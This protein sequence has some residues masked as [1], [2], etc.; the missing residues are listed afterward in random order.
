MKIGRSGTSLC[1]KVHN[2]G[3][4]WDLVKEV[5]LLSKI[6]RQGIVKAGGIKTSFQI[7]GMIKQ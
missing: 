4:V 3:W 7:D 6:N 5:D 2:N 1:R